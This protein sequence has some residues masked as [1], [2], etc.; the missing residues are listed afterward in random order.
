MNLS[1]YRY[2]PRNAFSRYYAGD[3]RTHDAAAFSCTVAGNENP[4]NVGFQ[5]SISREAR[6]KEFDFRSIKQRGRMKDAGNNFIEHFHRFP[7]IV[8][9]ACG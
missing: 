3:G 2:F 9:N 1:I 6:V 7:E 5:I 8:N 4:F